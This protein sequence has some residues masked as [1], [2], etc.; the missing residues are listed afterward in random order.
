MQ[1]NY[2]PWQELQWTKLQTSVRQ[3]RIP[4]AILLTGAEGMGVEEFALAFAAGLLCLQPQASGLAC[5]TCKTCNLFEAGSHP[6]LFLLEPEE[7]GKQIR[8]DPVRELIAKIQLS[9]QY[10]RYKVAIIKPAEAM[11]R[12]AA[13]SLL[14]TLEEPPPDSILLLVCRQPSQLP[15][16]LR[17]RC[18]RLGF[19]A[20]DGKAGVEW[21]TSQVTDSELSP[22]ELLSLARGAPLKA[23]ELAT[24][25]LI[26]RQRSV[27]QDLLLLRNRSSDPVRMA[28]KWSAYGAA[29]VLGW[30][31]QTFGRLLHQKLPAKEQPEG[32]SAQTGDLQELANGLDLREIVSC[33]DT[34]LRHY[35]SST[36][37]IS[38]NQQAILEDMIVYWQT[39][40]TD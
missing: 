11:N 30:L 17:S 36:G 31:M 32:H 26:I 1:V 16:T 37:P 38:L 24:S 28:E 29:Q 35:Y 10:S 20:G 39:I 6:D 13:N 12:S 9:R 3:Q 4:H 40:T 33:Y 2:Y 8:V 34:A 25:D 14:K 23:V 21:V 7:E 5:G 15:I 27:L 22:T 18:Q 19:S